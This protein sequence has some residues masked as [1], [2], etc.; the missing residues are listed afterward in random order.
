MLH[1]EQLQIHQTEQ[2]DFTPCDTR[3]KVGNSPSHS[4]LAHLRWNCFQY[5]ATTL[6]INMKG[7]GNAPVCSDFQHLHVFVIGKYFYK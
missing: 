7:A 3:E 1:A 4:D 5:A 2:Q 6:A